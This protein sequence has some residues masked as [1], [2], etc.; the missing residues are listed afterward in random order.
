MRLLAQRDHSE[1]EL[2]RKLT[3]TGVSTDDIEQ[4]ISYCHEHHWLDESHFTQ[5]YVSSR[6]KKGYGA[7]RIQQELETKGIAREHICYALAESN[8]DWNSLALHTAQRRFGRQLPSEW[9]GKMKV[10]KFLLYR[11]FLH[12]E[13]LAVFND[14]TD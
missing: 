1:M 6:S 9:K 14:F 7:Q 4:A 2:R 3:Q 12:D 11:G 8:I 10:Q 5:R 13:I